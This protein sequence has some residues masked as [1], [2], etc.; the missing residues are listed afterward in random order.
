[1]KKV[2]LI[3]L[4]SL[5]Y[6]SSFG[7]N[8]L[9]RVSFTIDGTKPNQKVFLLTDSDSLELDSTQT[10][11][12]EPEWVNSINVQQAKLTNSDD[13]ENLYNVYIRLNSGDEKKFLT[14]IKKSE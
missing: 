10:K 14:M 3:L 1:M 12:M 8:G 5:T 6:G 2:I 7:Q 4:I 9:D 11:L 13:S